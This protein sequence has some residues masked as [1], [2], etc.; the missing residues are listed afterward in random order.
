MSEK[1]CPYFREPCLKQKC[2]AY[3]IKG[4]GMFLEGN[5]Y[6]YP[7][8]KVLDIV[9]G[10]ITYDCHCNDCKKLKE[11][12]WCSFKKEEVTPR[13]GV[14]CDGFEERENDS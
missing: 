14:F 6:H 2:L 3:E 7:Y 11:D 9:V 5:K 12:N 1:L 4:G 8:C 13:G 10:E